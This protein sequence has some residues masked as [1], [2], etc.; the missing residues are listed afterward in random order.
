M[1]TI[2]KSN[3][4][5]VLTSTAVKKLII[6]L[7]TALVKETDNDLDDAVDLGIQNRAASMTK[8]LR[9]IVQ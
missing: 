5:C 4:P 6:D 2:I 1:I 8:K 9:K 7:L 3:Y